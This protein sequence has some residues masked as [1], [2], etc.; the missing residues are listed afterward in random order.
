M[1]ADRRQ[2]APSA[3]WAVLEVRAA[4][5]LAEHAAAEAFEAGASGLEEREEGE[6]ML[7]I[8]YAPC[9]R[10]DAVREALAA[11]LGAAAVS[12][13]AAVPEV[14]WPRA[15]SEG[16]RPVVVSARL[17]VRPP[18]AQASLAPGQR[19]LVIEPRQ[20]FGSGAHVTTAL[21]LELL[22]EALALRP[23]ARL[24]DVGC[25]SGV[26]ALAALRLGVPRALACDLD[27]VAARETAENARRNGLVAGL[28]V[29]AGSLDA[30]AEGGFDLA[31]AN[32]IRSELVPLLAELARRVRPGAALV[33]SGLLAGE[34]ALL[35]AALADQGLR[36]ARV[37]VRTDESG[38]AWLA[39]TATR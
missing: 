6:A 19:E 26:L 38:D 2:D 29:F 17:L 25:G 23:A 37:C 39:L 8:V 10:A 30:L 24:L 16:L 32:L 15:W 13:P 21:A 27:R 7:L 5:G 31:V 35:E 28:R 36:V 14:D 22:D 9:E 11:L 3:R 34:R 12:A 4:R 1:S 18:S 20:A 33:L